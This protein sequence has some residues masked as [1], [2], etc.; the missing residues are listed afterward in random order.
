MGGKQSGSATTVFAR[1]VEPE[2][3]VKCEEWLNSVSRA[4]SDFDGYRGTT[5]LR[6]ATDQEEY[7]AIVQFD[8]CTENSSFPYTRQPCCNYVRFHDR[9]RLN[10]YRRCMSANDPE[11]PFIGDASAGRCYDNISLQRSIG[12][13]ACSKSFA[14]WRAARR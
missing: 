4:T 10:S 2:Q 3:H 14:K 11:R 12:A 6:P 7:V 9:S 5:I 8:G 1:K 13:D